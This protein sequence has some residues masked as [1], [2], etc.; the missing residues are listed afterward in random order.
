MEKNAKK[1]LN[2]MNEMHKEMNKIFKSIKPKKDISM[3]IKDLT[4]SQLEIMAYLY[5]H[6]AAK[7]SD[8]ANNA[9]VKMSTMTD[10]ID[11]LHNL[12]LVERKHDEKDRR[13][14]VISI[15]K[16]VQ[17]RVYGHIQNKNEQ[18]GKIMDC[19]SQK[20]KQTVIKI[21]TKM[22]DSLHKNAAGPKKPGLQR[23]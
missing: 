23:G 15:S 8:L 9:G 13:S 16:N 7:M 1:I 5:E 12:G 4:V 2:C 6:K 3:G 20:E 21:L 11:R 14:I 19:L 18:L 22:L 17:S 10:T